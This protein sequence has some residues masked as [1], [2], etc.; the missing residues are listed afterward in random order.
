MN[1][2]ASTNCTRHLHDQYGIG[3]ERLEES[4]QAQGRIEGFMDEHL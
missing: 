1:A 4:V 2:Q 3:L